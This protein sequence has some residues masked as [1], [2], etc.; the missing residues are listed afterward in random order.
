[1]GDSA[2][3]TN[4]KPFDW[5]ASL[6]GTADTAI[7]GYFALEAAKVAGNTVQKAPVNAVYAVMAGIVAIALIFFV[8][9]K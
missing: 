5:G 7:K 2:T 3:A 9:R 4:A 8:L 1:M 6:F